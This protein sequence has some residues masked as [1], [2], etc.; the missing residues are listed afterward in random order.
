MGLQV[1]RGV[2]AAAHNDEL[3]RKERGPYTRHAIKTVQHTHRGTFA[4]MRTQPVST[5]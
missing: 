5:A 1:S 3:D 4:A 2:G